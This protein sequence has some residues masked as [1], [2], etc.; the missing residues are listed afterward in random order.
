LGGG[1][2]AGA[3]SE[4]ED[5]S[6]GGEAPGHP[7]RAARQFR[8]SLSPAHFPQTREGRRHRT[9]CGSQWYRGAGWVF[10]LYRS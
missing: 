4:V 8:C 10:G 1:E 6:S 2:G 5:L 3:A 7:A 9:G